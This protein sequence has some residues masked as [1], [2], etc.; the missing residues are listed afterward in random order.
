MMS[1]LRLM[2]I[3]GKSSK[4]VT[5]EKKPWEKGNS[6]LIPAAIADIVFTVS[7]VYYTNSY[8]E[9]SLTAGITDITFVV[10]K[11]A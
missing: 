6:W 10:T 7:R 11:V 8:A 9:E 5:P 3:L 1:L 2:L 4:P